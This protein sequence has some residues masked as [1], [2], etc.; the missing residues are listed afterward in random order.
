MEYISDAVDAAI[1]VKVKW[2]EKK[3]QSQVCDCI[4]SWH[5]GGILLYDRPVSSVV[6]LLHFFFID[7]LLPP[8]KK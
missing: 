4:T 1:D 6:V 2:A 3:L 7:L 5:S 8:V